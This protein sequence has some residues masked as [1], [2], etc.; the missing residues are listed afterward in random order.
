MPED[1][2]SLEE[3]E[4]SGYKKRLANQRYALEASR[5][6]ADKAARLAGYWLDEINKTKRNMRRYEEMGLE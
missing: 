1:K 4:Y 3:V 6:A 2:R 5:R